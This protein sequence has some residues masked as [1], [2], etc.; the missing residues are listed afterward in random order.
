MVLLAHKDT[1]PGEVTLVRGLLRAHSGPPQFTA[2]L[3]VT[4]ANHR[5]VD[6]KLKF[7]LFTGFLSLKLCYQLS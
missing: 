1:A 3:K 6:S 4:V 2:S 5:N 7:S